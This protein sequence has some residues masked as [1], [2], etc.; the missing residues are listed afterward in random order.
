MMVA[1]RRLDVLTHGHV[2]ELSEGNI[3]LWKDFLQSYTANL[4]LDHIRDAADK[5]I[6]LAVYS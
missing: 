1:F 5:T 6:D 2:R 4:L 3:T